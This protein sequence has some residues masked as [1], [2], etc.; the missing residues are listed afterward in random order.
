MR[1]VSN[2]DP[3]AILPS[4]PKTTTTIMNYSQ[5]VLA[6]AGLSLGFL[7]VL[8]ANAQGFAPSGT[9]TIDG[10]AEEAWDAAEWN[11]LGID[12]H[13]I[14]DRWVSD[15][16]LAARFKALHDAD[17]LY[18]LIDVT[19]AVLGRYRDPGLWNDDAIELFFDLLSDGGSYDAFTTQL[20]FHGSDDDLYYLGIGDT[21]AAEGFDRAVTV[22]DG[23]GYLVE[24]FAP[25][26]AWGATLE[27][28]A[29]IGFDIHVNDMDVA[30]PDAAWAPARR[31]WS[32]TN[33]ANNQTADGF[34]TLILGD[35]PQTAYAPMGTPVLDGMLDAAYDVVSWNAIDWDIREIDPRWVEDT[36]IE[37]RFK[38]LHDE[39]GL[40]F[41]VEVTDD[42]LARY[43]E[44]GLWNDDTLEFFFDLLNDGGA[45]DTLT[46][47]VIFHGIDDGEFYL[48]GGD[49]SGASGFDR[50]VVVTDGV[51]YDVEFFVP[52]SAWGV[53]LADVTEIGLDI[54]VNDMDVSNPDASWAP[55]RRVWSDRN[56]ANHQTA[57]G[58]GTLFLAEDPNVDPGDGTW[59]GYTIDENGDVFTDAWMGWVWIGEDPW[60][61]S[62]S[63]LQYIYVPNDSGWVYIRK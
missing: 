39:S 8:S 7:P 27:D 35:S 57:D 49:T 32:D 60:V 18:L 29:E 56:N 34:G 37:A 23:V 14:D 24:F 21:S 50:E 45:Y 9:P 55:A 47:Q 63:L 26:N 61:W 59:Y 5:K 53:T 51:G 16:D 58:Y 3:V 20:T 4:N 25:W 42:I 43:R 38:A 30:N 1:L 44:P 10:V 19:D 12:I 40:Y 31:I 22:T 11:T 41:F 36:D 52:W 15:T 48:G 46:T 28:I 54:H 13:E 17:G 2:H 6:T 62:Y 33:N